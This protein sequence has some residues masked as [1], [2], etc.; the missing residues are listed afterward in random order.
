MSNVA[1]TICAFVHMFLFLLG[2]LHMATALYGCIIR[3]TSGRIVARVV[4]QPATGLTSFMRCL[5]PA[6][7]RHACSLCNQL[8]SM[9][10]CS[11]CTEDG[12]GARKPRQWYPA[13]LVNTCL[14]VWEESDEWRL[15]DNLHV[16]THSNRK[17][18]SV[19]VT[20]SYGALCAN[21]SGTAQSQD[22][23]GHLPQPCTTPHAAWVCP[24][25]A[26]IVSLKHDVST[27]K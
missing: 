25:H 7:C 14:Q 26:Q 27:V 16:H 12:V 21:W 8:R 3:S 15:L 17:L 2:S 10:A 1:Q 20:L 23:V 11:N 6:M 4:L 5:Q 22:P 9:H 19:C 13:G 24:L 18:D